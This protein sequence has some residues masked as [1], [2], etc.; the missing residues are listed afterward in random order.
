MPHTHRCSRRRTAAPCTR[1]V[2]CPTRCSPN[3][4]NTPRLR[5]LHQC[6]PLLQ[7]ARLLH[8]QR[9]GRVTSRL[10]SVRGALLHCRTLR[11]HHQPPRLHRRMLRLHHRREALLR[12]AGVE[13]HLWL[14][15]SGEC[16]LQVELCPL[17][18]EPYVIVCLPHQRCGLDLAATSRCLNLA[19]VFQTVSVCSRCATVANQPMSGPIIELVRYCSQP[20]L[21][22]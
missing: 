22:C 13:L 10:R 3:S 2:R 12:R 9:R 6:R 20:G 19:T 4:R 18:A 14:S 8:R 5:P 15:G 21:N 17:P 11:R 7:P 16:H 1:T